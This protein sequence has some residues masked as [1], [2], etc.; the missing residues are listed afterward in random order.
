MFEEPAEAPNTK[1]QAPRETSNIKIVDDP[2]TARRPIWSLDLELLWSL[3]LGAWDLK[4]V[5]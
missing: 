2:T 1:L 3:E 5:H 4:L